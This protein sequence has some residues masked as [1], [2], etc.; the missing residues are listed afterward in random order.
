[1]GSF[2]LHDFQTTTNLHPADADENSERGVVSAM[3]Q[4]AY[5]NGI[6]ETAIFPL[7]YSFYS[8]VFE[9]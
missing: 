3:G 6:I 8:L 9:L 1:M 4:K 2:G 7:Q 5:H